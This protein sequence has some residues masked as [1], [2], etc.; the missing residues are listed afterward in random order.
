METKSIS[1]NL[2]VAAMSIAVV[3]GSVSLG[4]G[5]MRPAGAETGRSGNRSDSGMPTGAGSDFSAA[6]ENSFDRSGF[7]LIA[8]SPGGIRSNAP[9]AS[10][11]PD[12]YQSG[13]PYPL[14]NCPPRGEFTRWSALRGDCD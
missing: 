1:R 12:L 9:P 4:L 10:I 3:I 13:S 2:A 8:W 6:L 11:E 5:E 14:D 7:I